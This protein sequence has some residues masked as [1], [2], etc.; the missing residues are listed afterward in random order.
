MKYYCNRVKIIKDYA[1]RIQYQNGLFIDSDIMIQHTDYFLNRL[2]D[3]LD[4]IEGLNSNYL[5]FKNSGKPGYGDPLGNIKR[6]R[7][8]KNKTDYEGIDISLNILHKAKETHESCKKTLLKNYESITAQ[9]WHV[10]CGK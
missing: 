6:G 3:W 4:L 2:S 5:I 10:N 9:G 7:I 1:S 8:L